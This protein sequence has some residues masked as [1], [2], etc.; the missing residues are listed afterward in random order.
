MSEPAQRVILIT[1]ASSGIGAEVARQVGGPGVGLVLHTGTRSDALAEVALEL[2]SRGAQTACLTGDLRDPQVAKDL[3]ALAQQRFRGLDQIVANAGFA[4]RGGL[5]DTELTDLE[6]AWRTMVDSL[7][8]MAKA[9]L[10][11][12]QASPCP[13]LVAVSSFGAQRYRADTLFMSSSAAKAALESLVRSL[14]AEHAAQGIAINAVAPGFTEKDGAH[15]SLTPEG[16]ARV[17]AQIPME[18]LGRR[19]EVAALIAFLL[20]PQAG[21]ITGQVIAVDG[22]LTLG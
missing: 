10:P 2:E 3:V 14:A 4:K 22:G 19:D 15:S 6:R 20:G 21:Y 13:R 12:M 5:A 18:R 16:W 7:F 9:G 11:L 1:G 8:V 17:K